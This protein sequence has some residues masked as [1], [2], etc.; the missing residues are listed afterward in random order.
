MNF[1]KSEITVIRDQNIEIGFCKNIRLCLLLLIQKFNRQSYFKAYNGKACQDR[2]W[3]LVQSL[4]K[5]SFK[6]R[7]KSIFKA[8]LYIFLDILSVE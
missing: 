4:L 6:E 8:T 3:I 2:K 1:R 5:M 7:C